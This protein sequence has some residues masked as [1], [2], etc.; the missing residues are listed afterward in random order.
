MEQG[1]QNTLQLLWDVN[2]KV[3]IHDEGEAGTNNIALCNLL[4]LCRRNGRLLD[5]VRLDFSGMD[6]R[7]L[8]LA[9]YLGEDGMVIPLFH[10]RLLSKK[11]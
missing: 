8:S 5:K 2:R 1:E 11:A 10:N 6:L 3:W 4:E 7:G 9:R